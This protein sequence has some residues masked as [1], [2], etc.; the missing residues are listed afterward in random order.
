M[1]SPPR[2]S[3]FA[4]RRRTLLLDKQATLNMVQYHTRTLAVFDHIIVV[5]AKN[6]S[7]QSPHPA[8]LLK[9]PS[10]PQRR[11][12]SIGTTT[13]RDNTVGALF[14]KS[15]VPGARRPLQAS[16]TGR[17]NPATPHAIRALQQR[18]AIPS[19]DR[20]K[21]GRMQRETPRNALRKLSNSRLPPQWTLNRAESGQFSFGF[22]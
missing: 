6:L 16:L 15:R 21:S 9:H 2:Q 18:R 12:S 10:T 17:N 5:V 8:G 1:S 7:Y 19:R 14:A 22:E 11:A 20:R 4:S 3:H 13:S